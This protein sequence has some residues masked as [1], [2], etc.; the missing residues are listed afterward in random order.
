M[1]LRE[2]DRKWKGQHKYI[3][4]GCGNKER[5]F[6]LRPVAEE[7]SA[8]TAEDSLRLVALSQSQDKDRLCERDRCVCSAEVSLQLLTDLAGVRLGLPLSSPRLSRGDRGRGNGHVE[9]TMNPLFV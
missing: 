4:M 1:D 5:H 8:C 6:L 3:H 2:G 7:V 9:Y